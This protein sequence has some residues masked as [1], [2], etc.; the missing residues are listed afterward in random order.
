MGDI[1]SVV[2]GVDNMRSDL[3]QPCAVF[4]LGE[5]ERARTTHEF[6]IALHDFEIRA[7]GRSEVGL[8][9]DQKIGLCDARTAF[10]WNFI[11]TRNVND[12]DGVIGEFATEAS[13]E[14]IAARLE[15]KNVRVELAME[16]FEREQVRGDVLA[17]GGVRATP[18]FD[19]ANSFGGQGVV[20]DEEF[21]IFP[22][23]NVVRDGSDAQFI[24][25]MAA[26]FEHQ[27][28]FTA[29]DRAADADR[30]SAPRKIAVERLVSFM[31]MTGV[32]EVFVSVA[33][34]A[35]QMEK[36]AHG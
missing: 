6:G 35:V 26:E 31:E 10:A 7:D 18:G 16:F 22:R 17:N 25:E 29:A 14:I 34:V 1:S 12:L 33:V 32:V 13:S 36:K 9:D 3:V 15:Q 11:A 8:V 24:A 2:V 4:D 19:S 28:G 23:K 30:E 20:A 5:D 27:R 21:A